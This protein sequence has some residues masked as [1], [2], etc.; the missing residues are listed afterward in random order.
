MTRNQTR[1][2]IIS[3]A[4]GRADDES[5]SFIFEDILGLGDRAKHR[6]EQRQCAQR[7]T[8]RFPHSII[9]SSHPAT[10]PKR[11]SPHSQLT[12]ACVACHPMKSNFPAGPRQNHTACSARD[13]P[14]ARTSLL[15][16]YGGGAHPRIPA[17]AVWL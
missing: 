8:Y 16:R 12:P 1:V 9:H 17:V 2:L 15:H 5:Q 13:S 10:F 4:W 6:A 14:S 7:R 3:A 11:S